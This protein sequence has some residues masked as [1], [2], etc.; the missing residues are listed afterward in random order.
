[1]LRGLLKSEFVKNVS[2]L[3]SGAVLAQLVT[4]LLEPI[5]ADYY[6][7]EDRA[8][9]TMFTYLVSFGAAAGTAKY[10]L[11]LP[12]IKGV[13]D[14]FRLY[15][16]TLR[17]LIVISIL[18]S[19][20][21]V[22]PLYLNDSTYDTFF[23]VLLPLGILILGLSNLGTNWSISQKKFKIITTSK[24]AGSAVSNS[25]KLLLGF[26]GFGYLGLILGFILGWA[27]NAL[28]LM[29]DF[30]SN[31]RSFKVGSRTK[32]AKYLAY[33]NRN[34]PYVTLPHTLMDYGK[35][36]I[37]GIMFW[38]FFS[39][40]EYGSYAYSLSMLKLP[41]ALIGTSI[42]QVF[43]QRSSEKFKNNQPI[44]SLA[45]RSLGIL[46]A[47]S[48]IPFLLIFFFGEEIFAFVFNENYREAGQF[49]EIMIPWVTLIF[50]TSPISSIPMIIGKQKP[51][52]IMALIGS[53]LMILG[54]YVPDQIFD[55]SVEE[56]LFILTYSQMI[57]LLGVI[58]GILYMVR[59]S[60][61]KLVNGE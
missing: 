2:V 1:M 35:E 26:V 5:I 52:F 50:I 29:F 18:S 47:I 30:K 7:P 55:M 60:D 43:F 20:L 37:V 25:V 28:T 22:I 8:E 14:T 31:F 46:L 33:Q 32:R 42:A 4:Y 57:F 6:L 9:L 48:V 38:N 58:I 21:I 36:I 51:F 23:Y 10:E 16:F 39:Q 15:L 17:L 24:I 49:S 34:F 61:E 12:L 40:S 11:A 41:V 59:K 27:A 13:K 45:I 19:V 53:I 54:I 56:T 44:A 3:T